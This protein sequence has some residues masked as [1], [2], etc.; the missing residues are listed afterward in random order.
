M[1]DPDLQITDRISRTKPMHQLYKKPLYFQKNF[2][3][4]LLLGSL[5]TNTSAQLL[6][7]RTLWNDSWRNELF[8]SAPEGKW[9]KWG[10]K[11]GKWGAPEGKLGTNSSAQLLKNEL[12]GSAPKAP[13]GTN[14]STQLLKVNGQRGS[15][16]E[17]PLE[18]IWEQKGLAWEL[19]GNGKALLGNSWGT[20]RPYLGTLGERKGLVWELLG[21]G[22]A[23]LGNSWGTERPC[24]R[25]LGEHGKALGMVGIGSGVL[26]FV[27]M[28]RARMIY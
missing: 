14:S 10:G 1:D 17:W 24:L 9:G 22:K 2:A 19:L 3:L 16:S 12:F 15:Q 8:S 25:T 7:E 6:K 27:V 4:A 28:C 26:D 13:E 5:G 11:W 20:E 21:N 18:L 23:L